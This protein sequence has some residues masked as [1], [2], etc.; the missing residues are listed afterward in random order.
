MIPLIRRF[1]ELNGER[2]IFAARA[3][4]TESLLFLFFYHLFKL[5]HRLL[6]GKK[7]EVGNCS[8]VP[9]DLLPRVVGLSELWNQYSAAI[10]KA[11]IPTDLVPVARGKRL[12]GHSRM[13]FTALVT[14]GLS[15]MSVYGE[16]VG[17]RLLAATSLFTVIAIVGLVTVLSLRFFTD[18]LIPTWALF[19]AGLLL[20]IV[21]NAVALCLVFAFVILHGRNAATFLPLRDYRHYVMEVIDVTNEDVKRENMK[22]VR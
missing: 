13:N 14:H 11:R 12:A 16:E 21:L 6:T 2:I 5:L 19:A 4:R 17:T 20:L 15:A 9:R 7:V 1:E 3:R 22:Q 8:V 10:F 18:L